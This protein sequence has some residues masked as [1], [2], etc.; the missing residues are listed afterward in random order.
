MKAAEA[1]MDP[2]LAA[3]HDQVL[4]LKHNLNARA[5]ASLQ[6]TAGQIQ[7]DVGSLVKEMEA[8][9]AEANAFIDQMKNQGE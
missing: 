9:I 5:I 1:K 7:S 4:Y 6:V 2:V 8:A 3:F